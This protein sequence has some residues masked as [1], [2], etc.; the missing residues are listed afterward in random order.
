[1]AMAGGVLGWESS[2]LTQ[3]VGESGEASL[4]SKRGRRR[5]GQ[6]GEAQVGRLGTSSPWRAAARAVTAWRVSIGCEGRWRGR[7][8][9]GR[10]ARLGMGLGRARNR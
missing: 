8:T 9:A 7:S 6:R 10:G 4:R 2:D 5:A 3:G 1:M